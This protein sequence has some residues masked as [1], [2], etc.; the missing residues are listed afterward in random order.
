MHISA[1]PQIWRTHMYHLKK[2]SLFP[3]CIFRTGLQLLSIAS[4]GS[5]S[6]GSLFNC[7]SRPTGFHSD[8][9]LLLHKC[10]RHSASNTIWMLHILIWQT[11]TTNWNILGNCWLTHEDP[12]VAHTWLKHNVSSACYY[13]SVSWT[14]NAIFP[15]G[16]FLSSAW[17]KINWITAQVK[18]W[19][20]LAQHRC[21][22]QTARKLWRMYWD[23]RNRHQTTSAYHRGLL[24]SLIIR[25]AQDTT[26]RLKKNISPH[27]TFP[28]VHRDQSCCSPR[29][30]QLKRS[31]EISFP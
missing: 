31:I 3:C 20:R 27:R 17:R 28:F 10:Y 22:P 21:C 24:P 14:I 26:W 1:Y 4:Y 7:P 23:C 2:T 19:L 8:N 13:T 12:G 15:R 18:T 30:L 11:D 29:V 16:V 9:F 6:W 25:T 5:A